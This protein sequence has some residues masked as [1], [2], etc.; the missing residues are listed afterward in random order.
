MSF[1]A[2]LSE[3]Q[4]FMR[5]LL[6]VLFGPT[7]AGKSTYKDFLVSRMGFQ[8]IKSFSTRQRRSADDEEYN[9]VS[10]E[11]WDDMHNHDEMVNAN[12]YEDEWYGIKAADLRLNEKA[13]I[14]S[15]ISS[16]AE[17]R[18]YAENLGKFVLLVY[19][20]PVSEEK[21][22]LRHKNRGTPERINR[23]KLESQRDME[24]LKDI[25]DVHI[26]QDTFQLKNLIRG[27][28]RSIKIER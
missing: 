26:V 21:M 18:E 15:D 3:N 27:I 7:G 12:Y 24:L 5:N 19:T 23:A 13:V 11:Q 16:A 17:L 10:R 2:F 8:P 1:K 14:I 28:E 25:R 4:D 20:A 22:M 9:Y 6:V